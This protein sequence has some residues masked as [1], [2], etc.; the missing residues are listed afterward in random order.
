L[1]MLQH[2]PEIEHQEHQSWGSKAKFLPSLGALFPKL[3]E[4]LGL[5]VGWKI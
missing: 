1:C 5:R 4:V 2:F 3:W